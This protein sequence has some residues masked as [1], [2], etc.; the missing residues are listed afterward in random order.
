MESEWY[1]RRGRVAI[2]TL[3][4]QPRTPILL[5]H[6]GS[7]AR[8]SLFSF[9]NS[10]YTCISRSPFFAERLSFLL[11]TTLITYALRALPLPK[12]AA[13]LDYND[14]IDVRRPV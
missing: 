2:G 4:I 5:A 12:I 11:Q 1:L 9:A 3:Y 6:A 14:S 10:G 7:L 8:L 13:D